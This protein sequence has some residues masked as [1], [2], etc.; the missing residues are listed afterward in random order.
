MT[1]RHNGE[2]SIYPYRKGFAAHVWVT[3]PTGRRQRRWVYGKTWEETHA[4][5]LALTGEA[6]RG[7]MVTKIPTV[8]QYLYRWLAE[9]VAPNLAPLAYATYESHVRWY[10][11]PGIGKIRLDRLRVSD[12]QSWLNKLQSQCQ[13]CA[14]G[15]D[16]KRATRDPARTKC[17]AKGECCRSY[18]SGRTIKDLRGVLRSALSSAMTEELVSRNVATM[19]KAPRLRPRKI[20]PWSSEEA[21]RF[22]ESARN[23]GDSFYAVFVLVLV[24][25]L[26]KGEVLGL[27]WPAVD[28]EGRELTI[29]QQFQRD[30]R[31]LLLRETKTATSDGTLPI[32]D[33]VAAALELRRTEQGKDKAEAG[34]VWREL[35]TGPHLV[36]TGKYGTPVDPRTLNRRFTARCEQAGVRHMTVHDA[37]RT[38]ATLLVDLEVHPR[39]I[40]RILRHADVSMTMEIYANASS[41]ATSE[42]LRRLGESLR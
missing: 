14:Q 15:K 13:C 11:D 6:Q 12:V 16:A 22:L 8:G 18:P 24:L 35:P 23:D 36:F 19:V 20:V 40:M 39:V 1:K 2:G 30:G 34:E 10:L 41:T 42:A 33:L 21:R 37:R 32:P 38:C 9:T 27:S 4:K 26:R 17:C 29:D 7:P 5:W 28:V 31:E 25:G 3:S